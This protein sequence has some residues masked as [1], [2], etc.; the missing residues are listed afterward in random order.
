MKRL[1][2]AGTALAALTAAPAMAADMPLKAMPRPA[3]VFSWTGCYIGAHVGL[4]ADINR[5]DFGAAIA[6]GATEG[7]DPLGTAEF[8]P[9]GGQS[10]GGGVA[11]G[12]L[13]CNYQVAPSWVI[14]IE[15]EGFWTDVTHDV[16]R[17]EDAADPGTFSRFRSQNRWDA[18]VS[19]RL[20]YAAGQNLVYGKA[21]AAWGGFE[22][23]EWHDDFPTVHG[24]PGGGT[25]SVSF[26][27][28]RVGLLLG[29]GWE[30]FLSDY[31]S[32]K[33]EYDLITFRS[34]S[35]PYP[36]ATAAIQSFSSRDQVNIFKFGI[37]WRLNAGPLPGAY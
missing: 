10:G 16:D 33:F 31:L 29:G 9:F 4:G 1:F 27:D 32:F 23:T 14:G 6:S 28:T 20:G 36:S 26:S 7:A 19:F 2:L 35:V 18:D 12:Q 5:N 15:G 21:G 13:G 34:V 24:C 17:G 11:G 37:N 25:C 22:T 30:H 3:P 8:G